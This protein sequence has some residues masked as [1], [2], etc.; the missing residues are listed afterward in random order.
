MSAKTLEIALQGLNEDQIRVVTTHDGPVLCVA[1]AGSGKT[2]TLVRRVVHMIG[3]GIDP[4]SILLLTF[5]RA[6]A[7]EMLSRAKSLSPQAV[8]VSGGTFHSIGTM[9][10]RE[11]A[12]V[13]GLADN[14]TV[15][16]P[17]DCDDVIKLITADMERDRDPYPR[18]STIRNCISFAYNTETKLKNAVKLRAPDWAHR[19]AFIQD[20]AQKF[21]A[22]KRARSLVDYDDILIYWASLLSNEDIAATLRARWPYLMIDEHQDSNALQLK[23][24]YR[25][26]GPN[27]NVLVVGDPAQ[28]IY[29]FRGSAPATIFDFKNQYGD[30]EVILLETN[31]RSVS[32]I[33]ELAN[34]IDKSMR[35]RFSRKLVAHSLEQHDR[36]CLVR[37]ID[38]DDEG[39][40]VT[41]CIADDFEATGTYSGHAVLARSMYMLRRIEGALLA[42]KI[43]YI[44]RG[45]IRITEAAHVKDLLCLARIFENPKHEPAWLRLLTKIPRVGNKKAAAALRSMG[46]DQS[47]ERA[48]GNLERESEKLGFSTALIRSS[49]AAFQRNETI[50]SRL[51]V[52]SNTIEPLLKP[53]YDDWEERKLDFDA[54]FAIAAQ[55]STLGEFLEAVTLDFS[56]DK[57]RRF[58]SSARLEDGYVTLSTIHSAKGL[59]WENV[60]IPS[61]I[62]G[63]YPSMMAKSP[64]ERQEELR[65]LYVAVTRAKRNL[66]F[67][68]PLRSSNDV[69]CRDSEYWPLISKHVDIFDSP[70]IRE[71]K[72]SKE[73]YS[74]DPSQELSSI[75]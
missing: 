4:K 10:L 26:A 31:Y 2:T 73:G 32:G 9:V 36:P 8:G 16:D 12:K 66:Y 15:L 20:V 69:P 61:F 37:T 35:P 33:V 40:M 58:D 54:L 5:T 67:Y 51:E 34:S 17:E 46:N 63:N 38:S 6:A 55:Y 21:V 13:L 1:G 68:R 59:E 70:Q 43:P 41:Q 74:V 29:G 7:K 14:F 48:L 64:Q 30:A 27:G 25:L 28:A 39:E 19:A 11:Y 50:A 42:K 62:E 52:A 18:A 57:A 47:L 23:I 56:V 44:V 49:L 65:C 22:Y 75:F 60:Y 45:G 3:S 72:A 24:I 71:R 53:T